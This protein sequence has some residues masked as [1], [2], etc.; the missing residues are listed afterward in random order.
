MR[1]ETPTVQAQAARAPHIP[2][3]LQEV[4]QG[5]QL[6][7]QG[8]YVDGTFGRG[9][10]ARA[11][12][13]QLGEGAQLIV[14]DQDLAAIA[15]AQ[16]LAKQD[17]R[18]RV[19]HCNFAEAGTQLSPAS[20]DG[21]LLDLG[22]SS[23]Q[24]DTAERGFSF[25]HDG[26]LDMRM[27]QSRGTTAAEYLA[28]VSEIELTRVLREYGEEPQA[29]RIAAEIVAAR[30]TLWRTRELA[31]LVAAVKGH[32]KPGRHP[33]TQV[34]QAIRIAVNAEL[35]SLQSGLQAGVDLLKVGARFAV[36]SFHSLE[37]RIVK[38]FFSERAKAPAASRRDFMHEANFAPTLKLISKDRASD[39]ECASNPRSR[40]AVL[41]VVEKL[42]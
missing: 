26:P 12:L 40:S 9:G 22:V 24:L 37:D 8:C 42:Q 36:I 6:K 38:Q 16:A 31:E 1:A 11:I 23:P 33:A 7:P 34:F 18:V 30:G 29:K 13:E 2:V 15:Q 10:H 19:I 32:G 35:A 4:L 5:L 39:Q 25:M 21:M 14:L 28:K 27:D 17:S 3:L 20:A 41:R